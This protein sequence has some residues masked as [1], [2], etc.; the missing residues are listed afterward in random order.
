MKTV[1]M[2]LFCLWFILLFIL[3]GDKYEDVRLSYTASL[4]MTIIVTVCLLAGVIAESYLSKK[5]A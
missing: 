2:I 5:N 3:L 1:N 4:I